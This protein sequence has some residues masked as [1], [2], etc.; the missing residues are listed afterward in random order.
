[1]NI[2]QCFWMVTKMTVPLVIGMLLYLLVQ[3]TNTYFVGNLNDSTLLA[4]VGMGNMLINVLVFAVTQG[5]NGAL[6]T[7]V[8]QSFGAK[9]FEACG[10]FLNRGKLVCT[11]I[12]IPV[13]IIFVYADT[14]LIALHQ[15]AGISRVARMYCCILIPGIWAQSMFDATRRFL[16]AQFETTIP[17]YV[18]LVTLILHFFWCYLFVIKM[19]GREIGAALATNITYILNFVLIEIVC[20]FKSSVKNTYQGVPDRRAF[21]NIG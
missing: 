17:L 15:D 18:Q 1:M 20:C 12:F 8:S 9:K 14:I 11:L 4:G 3:L 6:E 2:F 16:S 7:L 21:Q 10:I 5:L 19:E 13:I